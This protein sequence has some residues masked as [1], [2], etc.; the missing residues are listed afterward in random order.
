[1]KHGGVWTS[2]P[3]GSLRATVR[4]VS[5]VSRYAF[6]TKTAE[7]HADVEIQPGSTG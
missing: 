6:G 2:C 3:A 4:Q 7:F 5:L 1:V